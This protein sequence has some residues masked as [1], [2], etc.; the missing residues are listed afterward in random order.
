MTTQLPMTRLA[1][2]ARMAPPQGGTLFARTVALPG[3][4]SHAATPL[5]LVVAPPGYG[6]T[7]LMRC[8]YQWYRRHG[9]PVAWLTLTAA[10]NHPPTLLQALHQALGSDGTGTL[11]QLLERHAQ[12]TPRQVLFLDNLDV[13]RNRAALTLVEQLLVLRPLA[14]SLVMA[15]RSE[16]ALPLASWVF[17]GQL[18]RLEGAQL[19]ISEREL[20]ELLPATLAAPERAGWQQLRQQLEGWPLPLMYGLRELQAGRLHN[21][22]A[23][24][25]QLPSL[26]EHYFETLLQR[27]CSAEE[28]QLLTLA[29]LLDAV[30]A[31]QLDAVRGRSGSGPLLE[32]LRRR[33][34]FLQPL[35]DH[36][37]SYRLLAPLRTFLR[38]RLRR[39]HP[40][41]AAMCYRRAMRLFQQQGRMEEAVHYALLA[42]D[43]AQAA[44]LM[45]EYGHELVRRRGDHQRL[46]SWINRLPASARQQVPQLG[47]LSAWSLAF[48]NRV[49]ESEQAL[50][51]VASRQPASRTVPVLQ[52]QLEAQRCV[53]AALADALQDAARLSE[54]W[55][56][57]WQ[58]AGA[59]ET[60]TVLC[61]SA[62][63]LLHQGHASV[64][65]QRLDR[66]RQ[67][68]RQENSGYGLGW[69]A[70][71]QAMVRLA[72]E[73]YLSALAETAAL[74]HHDAPLPADQQDMLEQVL[75]LRAV[76]L[77]AQGDGE[78]ARSALAKVRPGLELH[79]TV[80]VLALWYSA[81]VGLALWDGA[82]PQPVFQQGLATAAQR[83]LER[84]P[85]QLQVERRYRGLCNEPLTLPNR[86][87]S[88]LLTL[89]AQCVR[90][91]MPGSGRPAALPRG[92]EVG[93]LSV[94]VTAA[95][96]AQRRGQAGAALT[97]LQ[98]A[99][100][101]VAG[102]GGLQWLRNETSLQ[103]LL[104]RLA[105]DG[106]VS[107]PV[108]ALLAQL[109]EGPEPSGNDLLTSQEQ[110]ILTHLASGQRNGE[111]GRL[112]HI[113]EGTVKWHL[114]NVYRKLDVT[115]RT[116]AV[117]RAREL[118]LL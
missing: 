108:A 72:Q 34:L 18:Q 62:F 49:Q 50:A 87:E 81:Q 66:A 69:V 16:P 14:W 4:W 91:R 30:S 3:G 98:Q 44:T 8:G 6:K 103:P 77:L 29:A 105:D 38:Q 7:A 61:V 25:Q 23:L 10:D 85:W 116:Q 47:V 93:R 17:D 35:P 46:L 94:L 48:T 36:G 20:A 74:L 52:S 82:D 83:G 106:S 70:L 78:A 67:L 55:L 89:R 1:Q 45:A 63:A 60:G 114:H 102:H 51:E 88:R 9:E 43:Y 84:L 92:A 107:A 37:G 5:T 54:A 97:S 101:Q 13:L 42:Q 31:A 75:I 86:C 73:D 113:S 28:R 59:M 80:D 95:V 40:E 68:F 2:R 100:E 39:N 64:A 11:E 79:A 65:L 90:Q 21:I 41:Q 22:D 118:Q 12:Q 27:S 26:L 15:A 56:T 115:S 117:A 112:L 58:E 109:L 71:L 53:N 33:N 99:L 32:A 96:T 111:I 19:T 76:A 57:R 104:R 110:H 24:Q